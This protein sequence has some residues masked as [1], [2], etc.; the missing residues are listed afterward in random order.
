LAIETL[1]QPPYTLNLTKPYSK[2]QM[3]GFTLQQPEQSR[4]PDKLIKVGFEYVTD[5]YNDGSKIFKKRN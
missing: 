4:K 5:E 1:T 2:K 3:T